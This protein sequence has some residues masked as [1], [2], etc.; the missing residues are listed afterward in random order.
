VDISRLALF[1]EWWTT[2]S[3]RK[4]LAREYRR[5]LFHKLLKYLDDRQ[6]IL[7]YGLRRVGKTTLMYQIIQHLLEEGVKKDRILRYSFD[8]SKAD[9]EEVLRTYEQEKLRKNFQDV[10]R[11]YVFLDEVQKTEDWQNKIKVFYDL[12]PSI[13]FFICGS[14]SMSIQKK[15]KESLAGRLYDFHMK[16]LSFSEF[17]ELKQVKAEYKDWKLQELKVTP[18]FHDHLRKGGFPEIID[19]TDEEKITNYI[20]NNVLERILYIDLPSEFGLK[21]AELLKTLVELTA[22]NPGLIVNYDSLSRDLKRN[23]Q[24]IM[25]YFQYLEYALIIKFVSNI[26]PGFLSTSRKMRKAYPTSTAFPLAYER[27]PGEDLQGKILENLVL[28]ELDAEYYFRDKNVEVDFIIKKD[29]GVTAVEVKSGKTDAKEFARALRKLTLDE[30]IIVTKDVSQVREVADKK[31]TLA[32]A[33]LFT[34]FKEKFL[35]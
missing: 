21:D 32:P 10:D 11:I 25:S 22:K 2:G 14:A 15:A 16:P 3:V 1:N 28:Q 8:D 19:E 20:K 4:E 24:T 13:K 23:R 18:L 12:Y 17:L 26:R 29:G 31:I 5:P 9:L 27:M 7:V 30:G 34:L 35:K 33:W 6:I